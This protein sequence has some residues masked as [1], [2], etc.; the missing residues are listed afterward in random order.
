MSGRAARS[1]VSICAATPSC[2]P[3]AS[4]WMVTPELLAASPPAA[5]RWPAT[6]RRDNTRSPLCRMAGTSSGA[7]PAQPPACIRGARAKAARGTD[8]IGPGA[9]TIPPACQ[10]EAETSGLAAP[11]PSPASAAPKPPPKPPSAPDSAPAIG[12]S[13]ARRKA[14]TAR[15]E[16][17][18]L[19]SDLKS[20]LPVLTKLRNALS[21]L[22]KAPVRVSPRPL[23]QSMA[24]V[25]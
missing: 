11:P 8:R 22:E 2:A 6:S 4:M 20:I 3:R 24:P 21:A 23:P 17:I 1:R 15:S 16:R 19:T 13:T 7:S 12:P 10:T 25:A 14:S 9:P 5:A 18:E